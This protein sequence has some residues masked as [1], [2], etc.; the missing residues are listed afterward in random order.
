LVRFAFVE[1]ESLEMVE[2][3]KAR[4]EGVDIQGRKLRVRR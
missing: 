4:M 3:A 2:K 1:M